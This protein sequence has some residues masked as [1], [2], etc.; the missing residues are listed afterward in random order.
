MQEAFRS[1]AAT[2]RDGISCCVRVWQVRRFEALSYQ[3]V[4]QLGIVAI[5]CGAHLQ[6]RLCEAS[7]LQHTLAVTLAEMRCRLKVYMCFHTSASW[8]TPLLRH[9]QSTWRAC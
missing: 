8:P 4:L 7:A 2:H 9:M 5:L 3:E 6:C 1:V